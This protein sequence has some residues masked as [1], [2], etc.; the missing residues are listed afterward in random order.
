MMPVQVYDIADRIDEAIE[1]EDWTRA[2]ELWSSLGQDQR[3]SIEVYQL[4]GGYRLV[5]ALQSYHEYS[6]EFQQGA[7]NQKP[8]P[9]DFK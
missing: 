9:N 2:V 1:R 5:R 3:A 4:I 7:G 6:E 8:H